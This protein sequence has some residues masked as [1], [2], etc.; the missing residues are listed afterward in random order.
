[1]LF[2][3][4]KSDLFYVE[5]VYCNCTGARVLVPIVNNY[6]FSPRYTLQNGTSI[7]IQFPEMLPCHTV[8]NFLL[9]LDFFVTVELALSMVL[10][11]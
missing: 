1:M 10:A 3:R 5:V 7:L 2:S 9:F 11:V 6:D 4:S 8:S